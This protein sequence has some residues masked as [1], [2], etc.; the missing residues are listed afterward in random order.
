MNPRHPCSHSLPGWL[1]PSLGL[2]LSFSLQ[3]CEPVKACPRAPSFLPAPQASCPPASFLTS[4]PGHPH[5]RL[6]KPLLQ[7]IFLQIPCASC[8]HTKPQRAPEEEVRVCF[9]LGTLPANPSSGTGPASLFYRMADGNYC[10]LCWLC[11]ITTQ[12]WKWKSTDNTF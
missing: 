4:F 10:R 7:V 6:H 11:V 3:F 2:S 5:T 8:T 9:S 1:S 12:L